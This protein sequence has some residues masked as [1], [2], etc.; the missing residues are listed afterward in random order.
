ME[1]KM[2]YKLN[3]CAN[4]RIIKTSMYTYSK[5]INEYTKCMNYVKIIGVSQK[6][7]KCICKFE[8]NCI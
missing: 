3:I 5:A 6:L 4:V 2:H 7:Y 8:H 1:Q